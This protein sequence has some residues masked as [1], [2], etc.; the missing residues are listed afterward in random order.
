[1]TYRHAIGSQALGNCC[2]TACA[3][4]VR[5]NAEAFAAEYGIDSVYEDYERMLAETEPDIVSVCVPPG[6]H[7]DIVIGCAATDIPSAIH[8]EKPMATTWAD[9]REMVEPCETRGSS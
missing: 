6:I 5:E 3:D 7:A 4:I 8:R 1:M 2:L 9:C